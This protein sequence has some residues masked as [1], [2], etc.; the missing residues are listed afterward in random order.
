MEALSKV[1]VRSGG[2]S[3]PQH[4]VLVAY[5][6]LVLKN[7]V[8]EPPHGTKAV[9]VDGLKPAVEDPYDLFLGEAGKTEADV[10]DFGGDLT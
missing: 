8:A 6:L 5:S 3:Q 9:E 7:L 10:F 4:P 1:F 2:F